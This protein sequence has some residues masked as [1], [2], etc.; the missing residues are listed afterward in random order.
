MKPT[1]QTILGDNGDCF[2]ACVASILELP[3]ADVPH[4]C[5]A[6]PDWWERF[7]QWL[8]ERGYCAVEVRLPAE[9]AVPADIWCIMSGCSP[10]GR[11]HSVVGR[12]KYG[13]KCAELAYDP[14]PSGDFFGDKDP[15]WCLF[16]CRKPA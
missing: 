6:P 7:G 9:F 8:M 14:H 4:F 3:I 5:V 15:E 11:M 16:L 12:F 13:A 10:R 2:R 1:Q